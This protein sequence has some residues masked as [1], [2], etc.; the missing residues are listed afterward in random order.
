[1]NSL[2]K[3]PIINFNLYKKHKGVKINQTAQVSPRKLQI[4]TFYKTTIEPS[5]KKKKKTTTEPSQ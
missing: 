3:S 5:Q 4:V 1:M 2:T